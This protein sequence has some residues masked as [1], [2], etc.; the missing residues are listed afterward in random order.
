MHMRNRLNRGG[1]RVLMYHR[2]GDWP[3]DPFCVSEA[4][5]EAQVQFVAERGLAISLEDI[6]EFLRGQRRLPEGAVML[7]CD[8]GAQSV[9]T[10]AA[11]ILKRYAVPMVAFV[12]TRAIDGSTSRLA[13]PEPFLSWDE[14]GR[15]QE[16]GITIGS[17][18]HTHASFGEMSESQ[19]RDEAGRSR[20]AIQR[21]LGI[22]PTAFAYPYGT[23]AH[24]NDMTRRVLGEVG[25]SMAFLATHGPIRT[26]SDPLALRRVKVEGGE[27]LWLFKLLTQGGMD[28]WSAVD[29][30]LS[31]VEKVKRRRTAVATQ[32][33]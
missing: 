29:S 7:T 8:D 14:A 5:F 26:G 27:P 6:A 18:G 19:A 32:A 23:P 28:G 13:L 22:A 4:D 30:A 11:P 25:Y 33:T 31:L 20:D 10:K 16:Y 24:Y 1:V 12:T 17:H 2:F 21:E 9:L 15:L 3:R